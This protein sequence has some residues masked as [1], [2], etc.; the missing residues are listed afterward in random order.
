MCRP[1]CAGSMM[2]RR[3]TSTAHQTASAIEMPRNT[4]QWRRT[5]ANSEGSAIVAAL[6]LVFDAE[7]AGLDGPGSAQPRDARKGHERKIDAIK[8]VAQVKHLRETGAGEFFLVPASVVALRV[9]QVLYARA[10]RRRIDFAGGA[11]PEKGPG[12]LRRSLRPPSAQMRVVVTGGRFAPS[13][14]VVLPHLEPCDG[15]TDPRIRRRHSQRHQPHQ[16]LPGSVDVVHPPAAE[17]AMILLLVLP[18]KVDRSACQ[19]MLRR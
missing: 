7:L 13:P 4:A 5:C 19:R 2:A 17:P 1:G 11:Q 3:L 6:L 9:E 10:H 15:S 14:A 8:V 12:R 16:R 18:E